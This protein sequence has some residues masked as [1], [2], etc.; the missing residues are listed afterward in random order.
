MESQGSCQVV[1]S[2][3]P[4]DVYCWI[5]FFGDGTCLVTTYYNLPVAS[6]VA[7]GCK[8]CAAASIYGANIFI[9]AL[10]ISIACWT[11]KSW[12]RSRQ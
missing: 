11:T 10:C 7:V 1:L 6:F 12:G 3:D 9:N 4:V 8:H 2:S 5:L